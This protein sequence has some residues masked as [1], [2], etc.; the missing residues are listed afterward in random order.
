MQILYRIVD[1]VIDTIMF[2]AKF[3]YVA[4]VL[5]LIVWITGAMMFGGGV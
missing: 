4:F 1:K 2:L 3:T 5:T